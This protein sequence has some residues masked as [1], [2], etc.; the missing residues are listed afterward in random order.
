MKQYKYILCNGTPITLP[1]QREMS[2]QIEFIPEASLPNRATYKMTQ[3]QH[4][5]IA[6]QVQEL[7]D[8]GL[9]RKSIGPCAVL[10]V[11]APKKGGKWRMCTDSRAI[12][13]ITIRYKLPVEFCQTMETSYCSP[14]F[15]CRPV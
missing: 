6:R 14:C 2:Y 15:R 4:K 5:E 13:M 8:Q 9:I 10:V 1:P 7:L 12:S 3:D 11:L